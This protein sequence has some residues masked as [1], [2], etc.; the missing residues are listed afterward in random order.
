MSGTFKMHCD[1][2]HLVAILES[3]LL[4]SIKASKG[5]FALLMPVHLGQYKDFFLQ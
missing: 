4:I 5:M 2:I 1:L 3:H